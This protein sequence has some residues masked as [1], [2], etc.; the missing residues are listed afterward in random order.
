MSAD[1]DAHRAGSSASSD[2]PATSAGLPA[3]FCDAT[4]ALRSAFGT[5][6]EEEADAAAAVVETQL[7]AMP[8]RMQARASSYLQE[9][10]ALAM[11]DRAAHRLRIALASAELVATRPLPRRMQVNVYRAEDTGEEFAVLIP[12]GNSPARRAHRAAMTTGQCPDCDALLGTDLRVTHTRACVAAEFN[13]NP[14][15][16]S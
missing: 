1:F 5:G 3:E 15:P 2:E 10:A 12:T 8:A 13:Y 14:G 11:G 4:T 9:Q 7:A 6:T 16:R